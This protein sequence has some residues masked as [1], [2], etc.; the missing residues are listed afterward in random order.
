MSAITYFHQTCPVCGRH[1]QVAVELLGLTVKCRHCSGR[2]VAREE[3]RGCH[4]ESSSLERAEE[5]LAMSTSFSNG[6]RETA[7]SA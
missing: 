5:L 6:I 4:L 3:S 1:L 7:E 2:F